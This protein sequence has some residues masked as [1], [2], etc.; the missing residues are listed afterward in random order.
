[1]SGTP[2]TPPRTISTAR[3][4]ATASP[5][6]APT[7]EPR[8][9]IQARRRAPGSNRTP[10][11]AAAAR[12]WG[13]P[14]RQRGRPGDAMG[15]GMDGAGGM[16]GTGGATGTGKGD[17]APTGVHDGAAGSAGTGTDAPG[18]A[19][20]DATTSTEA[21]A[22]DDGGCGCRTSRR[23]VDAPRNVLFAWAALGLGLAL[24]RRQS[25]RSRAFGRSGH[26]APRG[27]QT[28][29]GGAR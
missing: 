4:G 11:L 7:N 23:A 15:G 2:P 26:F 28:K 27:T 5:T 13:H 9:P 14:R 19:A 22:T 10:P 20:D 1:M 29:Q 16:G 18:G 17:A 8:R 6:W 25:L 3:R 24:R 12:N 21:T